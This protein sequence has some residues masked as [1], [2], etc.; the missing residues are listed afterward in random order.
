MHCGDAMLG[1]MTAD[2]YQRLAKRTA[3][4]DSKA[5]GE[6]W[7]NWGLGI[8]GEAGEVADYLKKVIYHGHPMDRD[9]LIKELGDV[10]WYIAIAASEADVSLSDIMEAN[11]EKLRK[12]YPQGFS[13]ADSLIRKDTQNG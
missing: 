2:Q 10:Q 4:L 12:R 8:A 1:R 3:D 9:K 5:A 11:I 13:T 6:R 7:S